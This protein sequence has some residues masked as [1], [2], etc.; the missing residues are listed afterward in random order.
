[1]ITQMKVLLGDEMILTVILGFLFG[2]VISFFNHYIVINVANKMTSQNIRSLQGKMMQRYL[3]R[4]VTNVL[5]LFL[6]YKNPPMLIATAFGLTSAKNYL[7]I[8]YLLKKE[9]RE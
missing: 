8:K 2:S 9:G 1:M 7:F 4:F 3:V 6:V 5:A